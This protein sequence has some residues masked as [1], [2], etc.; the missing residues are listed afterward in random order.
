MKQRRGHPRNTILSLDKQMNHLDD[1]SSVLVQEH[2]KHVLNRNSK[3]GGVT[4]L[5]TEQ[6]EEEK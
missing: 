6:P 2:E 5:S 3:S 4:L 1:G